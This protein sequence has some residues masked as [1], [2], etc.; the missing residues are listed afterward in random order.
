MGCC[1]LRAITGCC[2]L[3]PAGDVGAMRLYPRAAGG[4]RPAALGRI[5]LW[6]PAIEPSIV[7]LRVAA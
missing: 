1:M 6:A 3:Y 7:L 2:M 5:V 4:M